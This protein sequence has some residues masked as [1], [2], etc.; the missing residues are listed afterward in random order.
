MKAIDK[1]VNELDRNVAYNQLSEAVNGLVKSGFS[2]EEI[3]CII[4]G[5]DTIVNGL[6]MS[7]LY[8]L[9]TKKILKDKK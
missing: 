9:W 4:D 6:D 1:L 3:N 8:K 5:M 7:I 2:E